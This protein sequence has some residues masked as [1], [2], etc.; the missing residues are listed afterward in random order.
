MAAEARKENLEERL[1]NQARVRLLCGTH[2]ARR[3]S[4]LSDSPGFSSIPGERAGYLELGY[5][6]LNES[7]EG[8]SE[9]VPVAATATLQL[10]HRVVCC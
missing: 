9:V 10:Y 4:V 7:P 8:H 1:L 5:G 3:F 2:S 6:D